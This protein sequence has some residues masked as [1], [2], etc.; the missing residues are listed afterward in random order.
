MYF[1]TIWFYSNTGN[2]LILMGFFLLA[3]D[4]V[5]NNLDMPTVFSQLTLCKSDLNNIGYNCTG[6]QP[7]RAIKKYRKIKN[8]ERERNTKR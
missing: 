2:I 6:N 8:R 7:H 1:F 4:E 3:I 5:T